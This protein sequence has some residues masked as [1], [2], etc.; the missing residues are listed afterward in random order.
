MEQK[1]IKKRIMRRIKTIYY[2]RKILN[3]FT[4]KGTVLAFSLAGFASL[5]HVAAVF[6]NMPSLLNTTSFLSFS[7]NAFLN[8]EFAVQALIL[9]LFVTTVWLMRDV[10]LKIPHSTETSLAHT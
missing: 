9:A 6:E 5:V 7:Y 4:M 8:T 2:L 3:P 10:V 1:D